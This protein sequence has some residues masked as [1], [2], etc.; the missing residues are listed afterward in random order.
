M[1][2]W[3]VVQF[4][5]IGADEESKRAQGKDFIIWGIIA[6]TVM[7]CVWGLVRIVGGTFGLGNSSF[8][9]QVCPPGDPACKK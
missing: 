9:P 5:I 7:L 1:F 4:F 2:I 8:I 6:L 3:G